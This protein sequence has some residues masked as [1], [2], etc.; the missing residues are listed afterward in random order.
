MPQTA[1]INNIFSVH[2]TF[3]NHY[4]FQLKPLVIPLHYTWVHFDLLP[5]M[6][7]CTQRQFIG[8]TSSTERIMGNF[9]KRDNFIYW[10]PP[11]DVV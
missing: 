5:D 1:P 6:T 8:K 7:T 11:V 3:Q 2:K 10:Q 9:T 4:S